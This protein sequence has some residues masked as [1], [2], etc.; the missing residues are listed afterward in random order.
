MTN[1]D[2]LRSLSPEEMA[3]LLTTESVYCDPDYKE[4]DYC[5]NSSCMTC[6]LNWLKS[7]RKNGEYG[8]IK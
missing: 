2:Y 4:Y 6:M 1:Y 5:S 3:D 7:E 8:G